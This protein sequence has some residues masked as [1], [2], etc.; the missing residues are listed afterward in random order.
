MVSREEMRRMAWSHGT[1]VALAFRRALGGVPPRGAVKA[2]P[3]RT[4]AP[5]MRYVEV[6]RCFRNERSPMDGPGL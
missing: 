3:G 4:E 6:R 5:D 2:R 1:Q